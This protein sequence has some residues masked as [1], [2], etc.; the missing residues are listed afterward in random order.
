MGT[1][2]VTTLLKATKA[3]VCAIMVLGRSFF[4]SAIGIRNALMASWGMNARD[5]KCQ[6]LVVDEDADDRCRSVLYGEKLW[7]WS[8]RVRWWR[9]VC[10]KKGVEYMAYMIILRTMKVDRAERARTTRERF[11]KATSCSVKRIPCFGVWGGGVSRYQSM[12]TP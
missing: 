10:V 7:R 11:T 8:M 2:L 3:K 9:Y 12:E 1:W 5:S 4:A 6:P